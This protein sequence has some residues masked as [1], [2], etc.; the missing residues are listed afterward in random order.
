[1]FCL[2]CRGGGRI[3]NASAHFIFKG[4]LYAVHTALLKQR[5]CLSVCPLAG[6]YIT[7]LGSGPEGDDVL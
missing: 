1:M 3:E 2:G 4:N 5:E 6:P 7:L